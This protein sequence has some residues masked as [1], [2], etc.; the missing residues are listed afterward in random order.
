V[1]IAS[2]GLTGISSVLRKA[3]AGSAGGDAWSDTAAS[4]E[5]FDGDA[6]LA[7]AAADASIPLGELKAALSEAALGSG[8]Y[9]GARGAA[10]DGGGIEEVPPASLSDADDDGYEKAV[11]EAML[12]A[13]ASDSSIPLVDLKAAISEAAHLTVRQLHAG[14]AVIPGGVAPPPASFSHPDDGE[15][16]Q[17]D[18]LPEQQAATSFSDESGSGA[19]EKEPPHPV[20]Y[21]AR[22]VIDS[23]AQDDVIK[24]AE[25]E[26]GSEGE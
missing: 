9:P 16:V 4:S 7:A 13:A 18:I 22:P 19:K 12:A 23:T 20:E 3:A 14:R 6:A 21:T 1:S 24:G 15:H 2:S 10:G 11:Q 5:P 17:H 8:L 25:G 26:G